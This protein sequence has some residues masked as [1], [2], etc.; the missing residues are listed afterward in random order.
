MICLKLHFYPILTHYKMI[1]VEVLERSKF[2]VL[3]PPVT[4]APS[5]FPP[6]IRRRAGSRQAGM[7][8]PGGA[9][10]GHSFSEYTDDLT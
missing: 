3:L 7:Q 10:M 6:L 2:F 4:P 1:V 8:A 5:H 9:E